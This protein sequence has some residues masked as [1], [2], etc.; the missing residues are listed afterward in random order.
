MSPLATALSLAHPTYQYGDLDH[1][2]NYL[3]SLHLD[4]RGSRAA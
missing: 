3:G 1:I 4:S 2:L